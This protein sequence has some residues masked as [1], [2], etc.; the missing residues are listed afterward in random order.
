[1]SNS[2][3]TYKNNKLE[4]D[5]KFKT[6]KKLKLN[7]NRINLSNKFELNNRTKSEPFGCYDFETFTLD[8]GL[9]R[10]Y[11][12][13]VYHPLKG[14][15][16][17]KRCN[18]STELEFNK[19]II[20]FFKNNPSIYFSFNGKNFDH[21]ILNRILKQSGTIPY[22]WKDKSSIR[23]ISWLNNTFLE[24]LYW[25]HPC[26]LRD[27]AKTFLGEDLKDKFPHNAVSLNMV[28]SKNSKFGKLKKG[29][30][31]FKDF[32][33]SE[34]IKFKNKEFWPLVKEYILKDVQILY[35]SL[36]ELDKLYNRIGYSITDR[37]YHGLASISYDFVLKFIE[38]DDL[39]PFT[40]E[41]Q[42]RWKSCLMGGIVEVLDLN[43]KQETIHKYD[44]NGLYSHV[45]LKDDFNYPIGEPELIINPS[46][47]RLKDFFGLI[48]ATVYNDGSVP[49]GVPSKDGLSFNRY[50]ALVPYQGTTEELNSLI[51]QGVKLESIQE[52]LNYSKRK[53][54]KELFGKALAVFDIIKS[55]GEREGNIGKRTFGKILH[56]SSYGGTSLN[57]LAYGLLRHDKSNLTIGI[58]IASYARMVSMGVVQ[59][60]YRE[61][62][63]VFYMDT[64][65]FDT[66]IKLPDSMIG[67]INRCGN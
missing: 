29:K 33:Y 65:S 55:E 64:D 18:Y 62:G 3:S 59:R 44:I 54:G 56:A 34:L 1:M 53:S 42:E 50:K 52:V 24:A 17:F 41:Q 11:Y 61:G 22:L 28:L 30:D 47:D 6:D 12:L 2:Q 45:R 60:I 26:S 43:L 25:T 49:I 39:V 51:K 40:R 31:K 37:N 7:N 58:F 32:S 66:D 4:L 20:K 23:K 16:H 14:Y 67:S 46:V 27:L 9:Q 36:L 13:L 48:K 21:L 10:P 35:K 8:S 15:K 19:S 5:S 38:K 57:W 63:K